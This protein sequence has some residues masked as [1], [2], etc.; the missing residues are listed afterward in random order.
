MIVENAGRISATV[1]QAPEFKEISGNLV[2]GMRIAHNDRKDKGHFFNLEAWGKLAESCKNLQKGNP[3]M[4]V[5]RLVQDQWKVDGQPKSAVKLV[6]DEIHF[7][8]RHLSRGVNR[9]Y[10][11]CNVVRPPEVRTIAEKTVMNMRVA[12]NDRRE[13]A[14][15]FAVEG[16]DFVAKTCKTLIPGAFTLVEYRL[17]QDLWQDSEGNKRTNVKM[18]ADEIHFLSQPKQNPQ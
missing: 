12:H 14:H 9:G 15:F 8:P 1:V 5:F 11:T 16:W 18:V 7:L 17:V 10:M 3:I 2:M 13:R 4:V 6:A